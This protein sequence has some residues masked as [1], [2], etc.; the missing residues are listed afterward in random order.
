MPSAKTTMLDEADA[1]AVETYIDSVVDHQR[2][3]IRKREALAF[4]KRIL[5]ADKVKQT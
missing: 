5:E 4:L 2:T 3:G 1:D